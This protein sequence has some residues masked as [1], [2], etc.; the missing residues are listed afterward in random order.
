MA[1]KNLVISPHVDDEILG[2]G[3]ILDESFFVYYCGIDETKLRK[4]KDAT[5]KKERFEELRK[6]ADYLGFKWE[7]NEKRQG[8]S[9]Y[10]A[11]IHRYI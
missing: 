9:L 5:P 10:R 7:C 2:C 4:D 6:S 8:K 11:R 3:G 1:V